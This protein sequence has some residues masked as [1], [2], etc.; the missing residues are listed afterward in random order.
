MSPVKPLDQLHEGVWG[1]WSSQEISF[2][3]I[4]VGR[5]ASK[6]CI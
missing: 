3:S 1:Y 6:R 4:L 2:W 5:I